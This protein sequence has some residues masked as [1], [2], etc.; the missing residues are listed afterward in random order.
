MDRA[1]LFLHIPK[2]A[3]A[4]LRRLLVAV[5]GVDRVFWVKPGGEREQ[6]LKA[7]DAMPEEKKRQL[8]VVTGHVKYG[9]VDPLLP[10]PLDYI[11]LLR[12]PVERTRSLYQYVQGLADHPL[13]ELA[14]GDLATFAT[15]PRQAQVDNLQVRMLAGNLPIGS[16][17]WTRPVR[18]RDW[19]RARRNLRRFVAVG[20]QERY[21]EFVKLLADR[22]DWPS[23]PEVE[24]AHV[25]LERLDIDEA[26]RRVIL[27]QNQ[28]DGRLHRLAA[29]WQPPAERSSFAAGGARPDRS[30]A[31]GT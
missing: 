24:D 18:R 17:R 19:W 6:S 28:W 31:D 12:D 22:L 29:A 15:S 13:H 27:R 8:K 4:T 26:T 23:L 30:P 10:Q 5:Y 1:L 9:L 16:H 7:L 2:A 11:T 14:R 3:G 20:V 21:G 25:V